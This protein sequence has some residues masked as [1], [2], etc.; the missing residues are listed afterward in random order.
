ME[1]VYGCHEKVAS[2]TSHRMC[3]DTVAQSN[4]Y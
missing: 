1:K 3:S 2:E 4:C